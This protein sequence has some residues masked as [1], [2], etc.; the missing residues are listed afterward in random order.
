M[1][2]VFVGEKSSHWWWRMNQMLG[3]N[4]ETYYNKS[5]S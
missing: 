1:D 3:M 4:R 2:F 5:V